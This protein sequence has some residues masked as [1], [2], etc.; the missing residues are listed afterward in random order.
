MEIRKAACVVAMVVLVVAVSGCQ[1]VSN[2]DYWVVSL[3]DADNPGLGCA[4]YPRELPVREKTKWV[5]IAN[6]SP[7]DAAD[8]LKNS[9]QVD[10]SAELTNKNEVIVRELKAGETMTFK[11]KKNLTKGEHGG[12]VIMGP[13]GSCTSGMP[14]PQIVIP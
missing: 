8:P 7:K 14:N 12:I 3:K 2:S 6:Y 13:P 1:T 11:L 9:V 10:V 5:V 4:M